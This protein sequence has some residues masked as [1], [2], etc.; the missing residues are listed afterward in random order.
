[1]AADL[2]NLDLTNIELQRAAYFAFL[3]NP[4]FLDQDGNADPNNVDYFTFARD[5]FENLL[6]PIQQSETVTTEGAQYR[7]ALSYGGNYNDK[8]YFGLSLGLSTINFTQDNT[9]REEIQNEASF[10]ESFEQIDALRVRGTGVDAKIGLIYRAFDF[11]RLGASFSSP[12]FYFLNE[13]FSTRFIS[14]VFNTNDVLETFDES[15]LPGDFDYR[16]RTPWSFNAGAS[17][18]IGKKGFISA[19]A[20]Y[21]DYSSMQLSSRDFDGIFDAD[22]QTI[23]NIFQPVWNYRLGAE[24]RQG[25]FRLRGGISLEG[26]PYDDIDDISRKITRISGGLGIRQREWYADLSLSHHR[27]DA[28]YL[29]YVFDS[30][31]I[32]A[33]TEPITQRVDRF[34]TI[35]LST[36]FYF[37]F[38]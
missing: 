28:A 1:P 35:V 29:P 24:F 14:N 3:T 19:E 37:S 26:D 27:V 7:T 23:N 25:I 8:L 20:E 18:F 10:L 34:L 16:L 9:Y 13:E 4:F 22:N 12:R 36:G 33:G 21:I 5:E 15:T 6:G 32:N 11:L 38:Y 2:E 30:N 17:I 31:S